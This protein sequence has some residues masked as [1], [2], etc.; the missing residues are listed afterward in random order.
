MGVDP[1]NPE[2]VARWLRGMWPEHPEPDETVVWNAVAEL[3]RAWNA[4]SIEPDLARGA[5]RVC[6][7]KIT[8]EEWL[9]AEG[10]GPA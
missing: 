6:L 3:L 5:I 7:M 8:Y 9:V 1:V 2:R 10:Y 4:G